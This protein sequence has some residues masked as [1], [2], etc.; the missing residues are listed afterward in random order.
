MQTIENKQQRPML[1]ATMFDI[2]EPTLRAHL[3]WFESRRNPKSVTVGAGLRPAPTTNAGLAL[4]FSF[5]HCAFWRN[6][7]ARE[8]NIKKRRK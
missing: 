7:I 4:P 1:I 8:R 2:S 6:L 5:S 3:I